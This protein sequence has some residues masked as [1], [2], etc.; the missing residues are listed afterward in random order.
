MELVPGP[1]DPQPLCEEEVVEKD[2]L[3]EAGFTN[4]NRRDFNA[5]CRACEK[6]GR[7]DIVSIAKEIDGKTEAEVEKYSKV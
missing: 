1:D 3:L 5:F 6:Y 4:W 7:G 2:Q